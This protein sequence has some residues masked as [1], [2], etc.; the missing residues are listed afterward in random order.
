VKSSVRMRARSCSENGKTK[1]SLHGRPP[2]HVQ[3]GLPIPVVL[4]A[5]SAS[6]P[7]GDIVKAIRLHKP[8]VVVELCDEPVV[9]DQKRMQIASAVVVESVKYERADFTFFPTP[10]RDVCVN[11]SIKII[12]LGKC[13][14]KAAISMATA[15]MVNSMGLRP[16]VVKA[17]P[18]GP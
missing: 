18:G 11:H 4:P 12:G 13:A 5:S 16:C 9:N 7:I 3:R 17:A 15:M 14:G 2:Q 10:F 6:P 8:D 1:G